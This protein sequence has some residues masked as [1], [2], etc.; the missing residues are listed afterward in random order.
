MYFATGVRHFAAARPF[1]DVFSL[2]VTSDAGLC[3][4]GLVALYLLLSV[5]MGAPRARQDPC[6]VC[7]RAW[8]TGQ[9]RL[10]VTTRCE[11]HELRLTR[12]VS[13]L[14]DA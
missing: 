12:T 6:T 5:F 4:L 7:S 9:R 2:S 1:A 3:L 13:V 11:I 8:S 14:E 10:L